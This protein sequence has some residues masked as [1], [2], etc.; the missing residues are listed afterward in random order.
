MT[1]SQQRSSLAKMKRGL[2]LR[3]LYSLGPARSWLLV[4]SAATLAT[5]SAAVALLPFN[6]AIAYGGV[7]LGPRSTSTTPEDWVWAVE[8]AARRVPW[9]ALCF[10]RGL[11]VQRL[12]RKSG[13]DAVLHY[14]AQYDVS[15]GKLEAHVWVSVSG[16]IIIG[17]EEA[18]GHNEIASF[19]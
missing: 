2:P 13:I 7:A 9:R 10:E 11:A 12:L 16:E 18:L 8:A 4:R 15:S 17:G 1:F 19:P 6:R 5:A 14:G 3:R